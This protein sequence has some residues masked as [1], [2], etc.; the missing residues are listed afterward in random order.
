MN[1]QEHTPMA[2]AG[3]PHSATIDA[4]LDG[5]MTPEDRADFERRAAS[6]DGLRAELALQARIDERLGVLMGV[7]EMPGV[8]A[9]LPARRASAFPMWTRVAAALLL[10][11]VGAWMFTA[12][13]LK[14]GTPKSA[15]AANVVLTRLEN[16]GFE[17]V[18]VCENDAQF[19]KYTREALGVEFVV[20]APATVQLVGWS[21]AD[22]VLGDAAP[23]LLARSEGEE[24]IVVM[25]RARNDHV[26]RVDESSG[27]KVHRAEFKGLVFYEVSRGCAPVIVNNIVAR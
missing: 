15:V 26:V 13:P 4:M 6:D 14:L 25:D 20:R 19:A 7:P 11:G 12:D 9:T 16:N 22:G 17:P 27:L 10:V 21:Y 23:V 8:A 2:P 1:D 24:L 3:G 5:A 18:W